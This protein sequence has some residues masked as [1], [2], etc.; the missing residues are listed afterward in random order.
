MTDTETASM[1]ADAI[2]FTTDKNENVTNFVKE[3]FAET[4]AQIDRENALARDE[5]LNV[6]IMYADDIQRKLE[7]KLEHKLAGWN[8]SQRADLVEPRSGFQIVRLHCLN[9]P[10]T[11]RA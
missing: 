11:I 9:W 10:I 4:A 5:A 2:Q 7:H 6:A 3:K 8:K 1:L